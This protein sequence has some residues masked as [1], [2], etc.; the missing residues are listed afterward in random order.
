MIDYLY[1][2]GINIS[3]ILDNNIFKQGDNYL[4]TSVVPPSSVMDY[5][6]V[7]CVIFIASYHYAEMAAQLVDLGYA[8]EIIQV[9][10]FGSSF[11]MG[12]DEEIFL[13]KK[14]KIL[15]GIDLLKDIRKHYPKHLLIIQHINGGL[16][17]IYWALAYLPSYCGKHNIDDCL[18]IVMGNAMRQTAEL[19]L[20]DTI[21]LEQDDIQSLANAIL[22]T[23]EENCVF[24]APGIMDA[25]MATRYVLKYFDFVKY[26]RCLLYG[27]CDTVSAAVP[28][29]ASEYENKSHLCK[30]QTVILSPYAKSV[31]KIPD[32]FWHEIVTE[33]SGKHFLV[34][35]NVS[36]SE[37]PNEGTI[38]LEIPISQIISAVEF[39]GHF[40]GIRSGLCD[41]IHTAKCKK[42]LV[43]RD[44][45]YLTFTDKEMSQIYSLPGW[46][47]IKVK[48]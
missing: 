20:R 26:N 41:I 29:R 48:A 40:I 35:T 18:A 8:G 39:A 1:K 10:R 13:R 12:L 34:C 32:R 45:E 21:M 43:F 14:A 25:D 15:H 4:G 24:T 9:V 5:N 37:K 47:T 42:T 7:N 46:D 31:T 27:L 30:G 28:T 3:A 11:E 16:G 6:T 33:Y 17:D 2:Y 36:G 38:P 23:H 22:F 44:K 19:F